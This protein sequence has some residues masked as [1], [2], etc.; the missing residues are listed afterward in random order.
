[1][2]R[3]GNDGTLSY[4]TLQPNVRRMMKAS[5]GAE[6]E[7]RCW[8]LQLIEGAGRGDEKEEEKMVGESHQG[9]WLS[10]NVSQGKNERTRKTSNGKKLKSQSTV[11]SRGDL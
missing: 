7:K 6:S 3:A 2:T 8:Y 11:S 9:G 10:R 4:K 1:M 5:G